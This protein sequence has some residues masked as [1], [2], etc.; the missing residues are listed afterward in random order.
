MDFNIILISL[1]GTDFHM[2]ENIEVR[3]EEERETRID[4]DEQLKQQLKVI[5]SPQHTSMVCSISKK[6]L[7]HF[8]NLGFDW[9]INSPSLL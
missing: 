7:Y 5:I 3:K 9:L 2:A 6:G 4:K 1:A 8:R